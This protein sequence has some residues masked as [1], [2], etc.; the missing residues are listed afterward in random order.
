MNALSVII[1]LAGTIALS[2]TLSF[3]LEKT[4]YTNS[5]VAFLFALMAVV[6]LRY[7]YARLDYKYKKGVIFSAF[8]SLGLSFA[9][10]AGKQLHTVENF[11]IGNPVLWTQMLVIAAFFCGPV[12]YLL[13]WF[14]C[15]KENKKTTQSNEEAGKEKSNFHHLFHLSF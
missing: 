3:D 13:Q 1:G 14:E 9:L 7:V 4:A 11:D 8:Y 6:I 2:N 12:W 15:G 10:T 5:T